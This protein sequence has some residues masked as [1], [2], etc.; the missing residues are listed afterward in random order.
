M[1]GYLFGFHRPGLVAHAGS[2]CNEGSTAE[3]HR[4]AIM[5]CVV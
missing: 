4:L 3:L 2:Q 5:D 1:A